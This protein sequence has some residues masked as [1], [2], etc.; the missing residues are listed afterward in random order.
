MIP[1][2]FAPVLFGFILSGLMSSIVSAIATFRVLEA[3][4]PFLVE[5]FP[6]WIFSW[7]VAFPTVLVVA[8]IARRIVA[9]LVKQT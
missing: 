4:A 6:S 9:R 5:W 8:P 2:R 3:G 7:L 1:A